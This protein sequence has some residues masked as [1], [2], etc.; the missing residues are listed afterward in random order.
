MA[1]L[2]IERKSKQAD[3]IQK[4]NLGSYI[5]SNDGFEIHD[6]HQ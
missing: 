2:V 4:Y 3:E 5:S 6:Q 1:V